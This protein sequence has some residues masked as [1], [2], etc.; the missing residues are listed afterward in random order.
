MLS[1]AF[2]RKCYAFLSFA[3]IVQ[4]D[5]FLLGSVCIVANVRTGKC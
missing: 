1:I 5:G 2:I 3:A 4:K